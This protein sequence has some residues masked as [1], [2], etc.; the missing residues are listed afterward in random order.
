MS[1]PKCGHDDWTTWG[2]SRRCLECERR[3]SRARHQRDPAEQLYR[4]TITRA[5]VQGVPHTL[6]RP[7]VDAALASWTCIYCENPVGTFPGRARP[8]SATIDRLI[9]EAGYIRSNIVLACH[10]CNSTKSEHTPQSL[11]A[12]ADKLD[13]IIHRQNPK[14]TT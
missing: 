10:Q 2:V 1:C 7:D 4:S 9:P 13:A 6:T 11:R 5:R 8:N 14:A 12:W 3:R